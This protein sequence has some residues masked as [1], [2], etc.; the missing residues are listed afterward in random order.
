MIQIE[1]HSNLL[2]RFP[3]TIK[4]SYE[5][6]PHKKVSPNYNL[7][8]SIPVGKKAF[9]WI[10]FYKDKL[11]ACF[12]MELNRDKVIT[13]VSYVQSFTETKPN[14]SLGTILYGTLCENLNDNKQVF[15]IEDIFYYKG[16]S[17]ITQCFG[18]KLGYIYKMMTDNISNNDISFLLPVLWGSNYKEYYDCPANIPKD[19][20]AKIPYQIHHIQYRCLSVISP[21]LNVT[22]SRIKNVELDVNLTEKTV[23]PTNEIELKPFY[24]DVSKRQYR[25]PTVFR[26]KPDLQYDVYQLYAFGK[27]NKLIYYGLPHIP[28]L[29]TSMM[30]NKIFRKIRENT[31]L[32][33][34]EESE[35]EE[36][37]ENTD[38]TKF[39]F[40]EKYVNIECV[41]YS[42]FKKW[43][44][45]R[46]VGNHCKVVH[47][48]NL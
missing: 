32:D 29:E 37:F 35:D 18:D 3:S 26:C 36:D 12:L 22:L 43:I 20:I 45:K 11:S 24:T 27:N 5:T 30:M 17:L 31:N 14:Y 19:I 39:V 9:T 38:D 13:K 10:T 33:Y 34:I 44:P 48:M 41:Y 21:Y 6:I 4:L 2:Q 1:D 16:I 28:N 47:I 42:K 25:Y 8:L 40:L 23:L 15:I 7:A 46:V